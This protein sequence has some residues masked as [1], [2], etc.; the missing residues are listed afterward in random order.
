M[1]IMDWEKFSSNTVCN[2]GV[3]FTPIALTKGSGPTQVRARG[4]CGGEIRVEVHFRLAADPNGVVRVT[5]GLVLFYEEDT[6]NNFDLDG[7]SS[8]RNMILFP[9]ASGSRNIHVWNVSENHPDDKAD[10][11]LTLRN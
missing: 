2:R 4:K 11:T 7:S 5:R 10:V 8:F 1:R 6:E 9:G 3:T